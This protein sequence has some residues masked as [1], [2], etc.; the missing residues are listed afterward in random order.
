MP[1]LSDLEGKLKKQGG[2]QQRGVAAESE[3]AKGML[4]DAEQR[5]E[6]RRLGKEAA[7]LANEQRAPGWS[8]DPS[9]LLDRVPLGPETVSVEAPCTHCGG[10]LLLNITIACPRVD[11]GP[12]DS[13]QSSE[14]KLPN[15]YKPPDLV[16][17]FIA[18]IENLLDED[19]YQW[20]AETLNGML[21]TAKTKR[22]YTEKMMNALNNIEA[23]GNKERSWKR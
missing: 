1:K 7:F 10:I 6:A 4:K 16:G 21:N 8:H 15:D 19:R 17:E 18:R 13:E 22:M 9:A 23:A 11:L 5:A 3:V 12:Q 14:Q 2:T 20:A